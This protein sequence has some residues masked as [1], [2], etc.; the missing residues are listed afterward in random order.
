MSKDIRIK[1]G[2]DL[3]LK[4][5]AE[6][7]ISDVPRSQIYVLKP[8]DFHKVTPKLVLKEGA[9]VKAGEAIFRAQII[10][11]G[12]FIQGPRDFKTVL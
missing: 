9:E 3:K 5:A 4:G 7:V 11:I 12:F 10:A 6:R 2:L 8:S 1:K